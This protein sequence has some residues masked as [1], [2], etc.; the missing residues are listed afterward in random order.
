MAA[1]THQTSDSRNVKPCYNVNVCAVDPALTDM[2]A[3][4]SGYIFPRSENDKLFTEKGIARS[5]RTALLIDT[6]VFVMATLLLL[7]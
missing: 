7:H 6:V 1:G 2:F 4:K 5:L 3:N